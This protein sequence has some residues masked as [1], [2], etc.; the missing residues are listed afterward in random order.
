[1]KTAVGLLEKVMAEAID[2]IQED[3]GASRDVSFLKPQI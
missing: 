2:K 1:M 3:G